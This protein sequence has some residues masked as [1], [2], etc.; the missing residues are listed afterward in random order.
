[1]KETGLP[2]RIIK[3]WSSKHGLAAR[4]YCCSGQYFL[5]YEGCRETT[6][7]VNGVCLYGNL[8]PVRYRKW[9]QDWW[10]VNGG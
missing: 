7:V 4:F 10:L 6:E 8:V 9:I 5:D 2:M 3:E 1:M